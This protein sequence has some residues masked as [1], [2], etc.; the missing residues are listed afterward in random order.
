M[1]LEMGDV[2]ILQT[3]HGIGQIAVYPQL[4]LQAV[5]EPGNDDVF[6]GIKGTARFL[7]H[8]GSASSVGK[9]SGA[10][11]RARETGEERTQNT[12]CHIKRATTFHTRYLVPLL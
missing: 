10:E 6:R 11:R 4:H 1:E 2:W 8:A 5:V 7:G 9:M 3:F 12:E